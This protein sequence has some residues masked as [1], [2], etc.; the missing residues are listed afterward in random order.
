V[1]PP[2]CARRLRSGDAGVRVLVIGGTPGEAYLPP[3][4][5]EAEEAG[6]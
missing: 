2:A 6:R 1:V 4:W 5:T 3:E